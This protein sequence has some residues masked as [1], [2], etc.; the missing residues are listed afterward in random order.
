MTTVALLLLILA[1]QL[2]SATGPDP[3][4]AVAVNSFYRWHI[5]RHSVSDRARL[6]EFI[7][8]ELGCLIKAHRRHL[9]AFQKYYPELKPALSE[10]DYFSGA[11]QELAEFE[12]RR[13]HKLKRKAVALVQ[14][15]FAEDGVVNEGDGLLDTVYL[16]RTNGRWRIADIGFTWDVGG[17]PYRRL[18]DA[19]YGQMEKADRKM[20]WKASQTADC[21]RL[22][23]PD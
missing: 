9:V 12:V 20:R 17:L 7:T 6:S 21:R 11:T 22:R 10:I 4:P 2:A 1:P 18:R 14:L 8:P 16:Q 5:A 13:T 3:D 19:L 15:K 23:A